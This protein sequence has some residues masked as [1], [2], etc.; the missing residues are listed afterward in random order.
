[1][2]LG[3][4]APLDVASIGGMTVTSAQAIVACRFAAECFHFMST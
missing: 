4:G 3:S 1:M 2:A